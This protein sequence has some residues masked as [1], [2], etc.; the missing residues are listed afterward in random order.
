MG[1]GEQP[2]LDVSRWL[3]A[4]VA[5]GAVAVLIGFWALMAWGLYKLL[6]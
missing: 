3:V 2:D 4:L 1:E 6:V 5:V